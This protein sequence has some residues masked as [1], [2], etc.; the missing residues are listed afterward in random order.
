MEDFSGIYADFTREIRFEDLPPEVVLQA[1][2]SILDFFG[3]G[4]AGSV[5]EVAKVV[6]A[7]FSEIGGKPEACVIGRKMK[8]PAI[9][10]AMMNGIFAHALEIDDGHRWSGI[11]PGSPII[12]A[13]LAAAEISGT[14]G[15]EL[16][17]GTVV[18]YE[19]AIRIGMAI[20]PSHLLRGFHSTGTVGTF[21]AAAAAGRI[22]SLDHEQMVQAF[23]LAGLQAAG[24]MQVMD[25][26]GMAKSLHP[27]K[28]A[29]EGLFSAQMAQR[30]VK[31]PEHILQ[32]EK[33]FLRATSD[34]VN[35]K[36]LTERLGTHFEICNVFFK[37]YASCR[38]THAAVDALL[39]ILNK[40]P[41]ELKRIERILVETYTV[42]IKLCGQ[43]FNKR[44]LN[45]WDAKFS[46][47]VTL[48]LAA[49][50]GRCGIKEFCQ[51]DLA[52]EEIKA[53]AGRVEVISNEKWETLYPDKRGVS[54]SLW[55]DGKVQHCE[56]ELARGEPENP[57]SLDDLYEKFQTNTSKIISVDKA[58]ELKNRIMRLDH[59]YASDVIELL[60]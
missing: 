21:G 34:R 52:R 8:T 7:Y 4:L 56:I 31:A 30:G 18:G 11:H 58:Q 42:A 35:Y 24:L 60:T 44:S 2:K 57:L 43:K 16:I 19:I 50:K 22:L 47:P 14:N 15:K 26:G 46:L 32:G 33:G 41:V 3:A 9:H 38:H 54:V 6:S 5:T 59:L 37:I 45:P 29:S 20:N 1:K 17:L 13:A 48:A 51:R 28:A 12:P 36:Y 55:A 49:F 27:G 23:G 10:S 53:L 39:E 25:E 40:N